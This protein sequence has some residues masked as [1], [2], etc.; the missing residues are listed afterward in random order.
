MEQYHKFVAEYNV[1]V[2]EFQDNISELRKVVKTG[3]EPPS[4]KLAKELTAPR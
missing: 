2:Q 3:I 4:V 1:F